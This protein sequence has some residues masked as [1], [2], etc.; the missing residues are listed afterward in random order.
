[1]NSITELKEALLADYI[2]EIEQY[3]KDRLVQEL[4]II[5]SKELR[6]QDN[7]MVHEQK[8]VRTRKSK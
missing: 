5:K 8:Y 7:S 3:S 2:M 6:L 4:I 1:M